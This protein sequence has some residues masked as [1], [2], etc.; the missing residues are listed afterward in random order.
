VAVGTSV[1][2]S[3][4]RMG[5]S[6]ARKRS[7]S[8]KENWD[9][10]KTQAMKREELANRGQEF[11]GEIVQAV[12]S[13]WQWGG[14]EPS[15]AGSEPS[16][17]GVPKPNYVPHGR[18]MALGVEE[19]YEDQAARTPPEGANIITLG[20]SSL[21]W[22][23]ADPPADADAKERNANRQAAPVGWSAGEGQGRGAVMGI[24]GG[25]K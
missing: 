7:R 9:A 15:S 25:R 16:T 12:D 2:P 14:E 11:A 10:Q 20:N 4:P 19:F 21:S 23:S 22:T 1:Y 17:S 18:K 6:N 24:L 5:A 3:V 13:Q 8:P